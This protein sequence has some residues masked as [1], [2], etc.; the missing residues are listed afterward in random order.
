MKD[1]IVN[2]YRAGAYIIRM[3]CNVKIYKARV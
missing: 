2:I 1:W 3:I